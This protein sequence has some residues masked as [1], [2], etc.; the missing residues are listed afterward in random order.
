MGE[1]VE[2]V[3]TL[4]SVITNICE[5]YKLN[6]EDVK[7]EVL[8]VPLKVNAHYDSFEG[9][10]QQH[11][12]ADYDLTQFK[13]LIEEEPDQSGKALPFI[14]RFVMGEFKYAQ[15]VTRLHPNQKPLSRKSI[16]SAEEV[17]KKKGSKSKAVTD[18]FDILADEN[19]YL[20][21]HQRA[22]WEDL[23]DQSVWDAY[24]LD[25]VN[26]KLSKGDRVYEAGCGVLAFLHS[27]V[28]QHKSMNIEIGGMDGAPRTIRFLKE[29]MVCDEMKENFTVGLLPKGL[30]GIKDASWDCVVCN[31]VFQ[32]IPTPEE[33]YDTVIGMIRISKKWVI[34]ADICD[35]LF[36]ERTSKRIKQ[37]DQYKDYLP[38]FQF[39]DK[40]WWLQFQDE[41]HLVSLRH[42]DVPGYKRRTERYCVY[43]EKLN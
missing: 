35:E 21:L 5:K 18:L 15:R 39:F 32:Y 29:K 43:I 25:V 20:H 3:L 30:D 12:Y 31:S 33:A 28:S 16:P 38:N 4:S 37:M 26:N 41:N 8:D 36:E 24:V 11:S 42:V 19:R 1:S 27:L 2:G 9:K 23:E 40:K 22:G 6:V 14:L 17:E 13:K 10:G 7:R 34:I